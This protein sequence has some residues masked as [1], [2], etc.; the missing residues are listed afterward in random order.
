MINSFAPHLLNQVSQRFPEMLAAVNNVLA[1][2]DQK[3]L[4][5][6]IKSEAGSGAGVED[7]HDIP[8]GSLSLPDVQ[9]LLDIG[10]GDLIP[11]VFLP[12]Q[13][14]HEII[15]MLNSATLIENPSVNP[16]S[17]EWMFQML[18]KEMKAI[19]R[20]QTLMSVHHWQMLVKK[21]ENPNIS[22]AEVM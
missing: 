6:I 12:N 18:N 4:L 7:E 10:I 13:S 9:I 19:I 14:I 15:N 8:E 3:S 2:I 1:W 20:R 21:L 11:L 22:H 17:N 5:G 16:K